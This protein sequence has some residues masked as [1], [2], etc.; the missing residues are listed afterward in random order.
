MC[1]QACIT[2]LYD[3]ELGRRYVI[4]HSAIYDCHLFPSYLTYKGITFAQN[5]L[6]LDVLIQVD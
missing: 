3:T 1:C 6:E 5:P 2:I 4:G